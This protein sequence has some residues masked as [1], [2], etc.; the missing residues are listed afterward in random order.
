M[1]VF[2]AVIMGKKPSIFVSHTEQSWTH[3]Y[4]PRWQI[5]FFQCGWTRDPALL[6]HARL[7][8]ITVP[9]I[10]NTKM[11][12]LISKKRSKNNVLNSPTMF[13]MENYLYI[14]S[15]SFYWNWNL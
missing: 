11:D 4:I 8:C 9:T 12:Q 1:V 7:I 6:M 15:P 14:S 2:T 13:K 5:A 10:T 3:A